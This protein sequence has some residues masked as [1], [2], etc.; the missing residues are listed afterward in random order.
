MLLAFVA[1]GWLFAPV[2]RTEIAA[3]LATAAIGVVAWAGAAIVAA[4]APRAANDN[5]NDADQAFSGS[6]PQ[7]ISE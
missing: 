4:R 6:W 1:L 5:D 7:F 2:P 3:L